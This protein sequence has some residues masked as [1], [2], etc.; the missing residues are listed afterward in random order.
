MTSRSW[1]E[2][3]VHSKMKIWSSF[4]YPHVHYLLSGTQKIFWKKS[5]FLSIH[6]KSMR[7][8]CVLDSSVPQNTFFCVWSLRFGTIWEHLD[9]L[10]L[11]FT[12]RVILG[13]L[14]LKGVL[15]LIIE[16]SP[17]D[18][19]KMLVKGCSNRDMFTK[20]QHEIIV[21]DLYL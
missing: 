12:I 2:R 21:W 9:Y 5:L 1:K 16:M 15:R 14:S 19:D 17:P 20:K 7:V 11:L 18:T 6:W 3:I 13:K 8:Q 10:E 4:T